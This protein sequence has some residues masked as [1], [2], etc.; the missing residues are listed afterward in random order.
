MK[1]AQASIMTCPRE[2]SGEGDPHN[3]WRRAITHLEHQPTAK[4][5]SAPVRR[6]IEKF[7]YCFS[8]SLLPVFEFWHP[9]TRLK[10]LAGGSDLVWQLART[11][12]SMHRN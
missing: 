6:L 4:R 10:Y 9:I 5:L 3:A 8:P 1:P 11:C 2:P 12:P 7:S